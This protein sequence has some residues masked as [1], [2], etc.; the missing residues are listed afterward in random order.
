MINPLPEVPNPTTVT[1]PSDESPVETKKE[2]LL[3]TTAEEDQ[4]E[5][6]TTRC[7]QILDDLTDLRFEQEEELDKEKEEFNLI[8]ADVDEVASKSSIDTPF[9]SPFIVR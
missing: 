6:V 5:Q 8:K 2:D 9:S 4:I 7:A 1:P 3:L